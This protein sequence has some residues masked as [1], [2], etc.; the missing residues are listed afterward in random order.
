MFGKLRRRRFGEILVGD[1]LITQVQLDEA[2]EIQ[3]RCGDNVGAILLDLGYISEVDIIK[4]LSIQYQ[5]PCLRPTNYDINRSLLDLF[6]RV[7]LH[8]HLI[9]PFDKV[10]NLLLVLLQ[11]IPT[12]EVLEE[13]Q[14]VSGCD[15][16]IYLGTSHDIKQALMQLVPISKGDED[17]IRSLRI[18]QRDLGRDDD[19]AA[20]RGESGEVDSMEISS[21]KLLSSL[22][23][24]W[25]SIFVQ[26]SATNTDEDNDD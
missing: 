26:G 17:K 10:G 19:D 4:A 7:F 3:R 11:D 12:K 16:A 22:D 6:D 5:L 9:L 23:A 13:S 8:R 15:L 1:G 2:L 14:K 24:A 20:A 21:E 25:E 18:S